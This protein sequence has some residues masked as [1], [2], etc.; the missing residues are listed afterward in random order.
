MF[1]IK[2][3]RKIFVNVPLTFERSKG[4][5]FAKNDLVSA[6]FDLNLIKHY[7]TIELKG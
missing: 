4:C 2:A 7:L 1:E 6:H 5:A 3:K